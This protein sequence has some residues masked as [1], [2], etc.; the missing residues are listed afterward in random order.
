MTGVQTCAL[1]I[2]AAAPALTTPAWPTSF[3]SSPAPFSASAIVEGAQAF[4]AHCAQ[5]H[6]ARAKGDGPL[7]ARLATRPADLTQDHLFAHLDGD[8]F[9][10]IS[11]GLGAMPGFA[12]T[13]DAG[14]IWSLVDFLHANADGARLAALNG[15]VAGAAFPLPEFALSCPDAKAT[16]STDF[17][18][19]PLHIVVADQSSQARLRQLSFLAAGLDLRTIVVRD[20][21]VELP[22]GNWKPCV[23]DDPALASAL[24]V[25]AAQENAAGTEF[26]VDARSRLRSMW[27]ADSA[28]D[29][30]DPLAFRRA[31]NEMK[32]PQDLARALGAV[33]A[34]PGATGARYDLDGHRH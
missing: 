19:A 14:A 17:V 2:S 13:L 33:N 7:A 23:A 16:A 32:V 24:A 20:G 11:R 3:Q 28:T 4:A 26:L 29:W 12:A 9:W 22:Q 31:L 6:G 34:A 25:Y 1:P 8:L 21:E 18:G 27:R 15:R 5:C 10:Q 30:R